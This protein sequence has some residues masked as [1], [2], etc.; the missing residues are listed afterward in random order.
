[1][2]LLLTGSRVPLNAGDSEGEGSTSGFD[3]KIKDVRSDVTS[4][5]HESPGFERSRMYQSAGLTRARVRVS[6]R[7]DCH[8]RRRYDGISKRDTI[9]TQ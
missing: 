8:G 9:S 1:M 2:L 5:E 3:R 4:R 6:W 7:V